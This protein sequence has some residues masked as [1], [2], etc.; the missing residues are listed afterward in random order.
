M[1]NKSK[2]Y[3]ARVVYINDITFETVRRRGSNL[4]YFGMSIFYCLFI[5]FCLVLTL[6]FFFSFIFLLLGFFSFLPKAI[7]IACAL[8]AKTV[9]SNVYLFKA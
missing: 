1:L 6:M 9:G 2:G 3:V 8:R 5:V 4:G 7:E